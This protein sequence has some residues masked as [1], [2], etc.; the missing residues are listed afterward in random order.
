D[1]TGFLKYVDEIE[2]LEF[3]PANLIT[4]LSNITKGI[5]PQELVDEA[6]CLYEEL[7]KPYDREK[8]VCRFVKHMLHFAG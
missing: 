4:Y 6:E 5:I 1:K 7:D 2:P 3:D 8:L